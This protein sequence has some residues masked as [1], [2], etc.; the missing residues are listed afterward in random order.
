MLTATQEYWNP[1]Q[2]KCKTQR[3]HSQLSKNRKAIKSA[4][5][6]I[7]MLK[8]ESNPNI[9]PK[10]KEKQRKNEENHK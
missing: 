1:T 3:R 5:S 2:K 4:S 8:M 10:A 6:E 7:G 9:R